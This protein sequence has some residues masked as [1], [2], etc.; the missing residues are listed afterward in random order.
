MKSP[1]KFLAALA[2]AVAVGVSGTAQA[3]DHFD[4]PAMMANPQADIGDIYAWTAPDGRHLNLAMTIVGHSLSDRL[5]YT[6]HVDSGRAFGRTTAS[7][8]IVCRFPEPKVADCR[9]GA[10]DSARGD[11]TDPAGLASRNQRFRVFAGL[12][13]DPFYNNVKGALGAYGVAAAAV[14]AGAPVDAAGCA[15][16]DA[17]TV[18]AIRDQWRHTDGGP[19][20]NL[21]AN[22]TVSA[23]V[24]SVDLPVVSKGGPILAVWGTTASPK[25]RLER[26]ARPFVKNTLLGSAPFSTDKASGDLRQRYNEATPATATAYAVKIEKSLAMQDSLDG[27]CGNQLLANKAPDSPRRYRAL[28]RVFADDRLWVNGA[29]RACTQFF[30][31]ELAALAGLKDYAADCGGRSPTYDAP[32]MWR[33]VLIAGAVDGVHWDGL[34]HDEHVPSATEFPF[35]APPDPHGIDH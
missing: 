35:L 30:A 12:R 16:F 10:V 28:A 14:K 23:I 13:D 15:H 31:V 26:T 7:T 21:L 1:T 33:S 22:W 25:Q 18:G 29:S 34:D 3:S 20:Q 17:A 5:T 6:F 27:T 32:N 2:A 11:A 24:V 8:T 4:S 9:V 19:P